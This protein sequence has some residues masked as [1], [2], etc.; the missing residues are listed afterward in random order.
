M[1]T[2]PPQSCFQHAVDAPATLSATLHLLKSHTLLLVK[3]KLEE[4]EGKREELI[5]LK[6]CYTKILW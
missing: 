1:N 6:I 4:K 5:L 3:I 2:M